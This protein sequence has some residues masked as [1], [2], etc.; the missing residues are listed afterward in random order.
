VYRRLAEASVAF[1]HRRYNRLIAESKSAETLA[2]PYWE[3]GREAFHDQ[4]V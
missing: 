3:S 4:L 1:Q 2:L